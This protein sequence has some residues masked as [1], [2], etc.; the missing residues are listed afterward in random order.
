MGTQFLLGPSLM[1]C[2]ILREALTS[3]EC[4][5]PKGIWY[6][7]FDLR[8][9]P[10]SWL[11]GTGAEVT[12]QLPMTVHVFLDEEEKAEGQL[13]MDDG[14]SIDHLE[15]EAFSLATTEFHERSLT[16]RLFIKGYSS[17]Q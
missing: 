16:F 12:L 15:N 14:Y 7:G 1:I 10:G 17:G 13:Y 8:S 11:E 6:E 5:F 4:Y 3:R 9:R 2:P